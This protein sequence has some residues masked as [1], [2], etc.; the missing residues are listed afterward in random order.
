MLGQ[1]HFHSFVFFTFTVMLLVK[2]LPGMEVFLLLE[3]LIIPFYMLFML[4]RVANQGWLVTMGKTVVVGMLYA[5]SLVSLLLLTIMV[6]IMF[7]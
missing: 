5:A 4:K 7:V 2:P 1:I 3:A 6:S